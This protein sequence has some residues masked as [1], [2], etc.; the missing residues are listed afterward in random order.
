MASE[1][2]FR[3]LTAV[4]EDAAKT[5]LATA[6]AKLKNYLDAAGANGAAWNT[7]LESDKLDAQLKAPKVEDLTAILDRFQA[8]QPGL[9]LPIFA[10]VTGALSR[11][12]DVVQARQSDLQSQFAQRL[13]ELSEKLKS[14]PQDPSEEAAIALGGQLGWLQAAEQAR[15]WWRRFV[16]GTRS[17]TCTPMYLP[18]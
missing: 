6:I 9:E 3:P 18:N 12:I 10:N 7:Y 16:H 2:Y 15:R 17:P 13:K 1:A 8:N 4:D 5:A 14:Y 11:Y